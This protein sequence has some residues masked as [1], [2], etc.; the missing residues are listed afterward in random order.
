MYLEIQYSKLGFCRCTHQTSKIGDI[1]A[2]WNIGE[3]ASASRRCRCC[4]NRIRRPRYWWWRNCGGRKTAAVNS[5]VKTRFFFENR[6]PTAVNST[7]KQVLPVSRLSPA[8]S[9]QTSTVHFT[10]TCI[11]LQ[12][13][14]EANVYTVT[15]SPGCPHRRRRHHSKGCRRLRATTAAAAPAGSTW[16]RGQVTGEARCG[17]GGLSCGEGASMAVVRRSVIRL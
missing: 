17:G 8:H 13:W 3:S 16:G 1:G 15:R 7:T 12:R 6:P 10:E 4:K 14:H 9:P 2:S 11:Y 5:D